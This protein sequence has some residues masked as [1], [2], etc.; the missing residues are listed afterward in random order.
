MAHPI[1]KFT[2]AGIMTGLGLTPDSAIT[3]IK[4]E[5]ISSP[6]VCVHFDVGCFRLFKFVV[7][8]NFCKQSTYKNYDQFLTSLDISLLKIFKTRKFNLF[9]VAMAQEIQTNLSSHF[10]LVI[11]IFFWIYTLTDQI[12]KVSVLLFIQISFS[13]SN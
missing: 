1:A 6:S 13:C 11:V 10:S 4:K 2:S 5:I 7:R 8:L 9:F 12:S 3:G